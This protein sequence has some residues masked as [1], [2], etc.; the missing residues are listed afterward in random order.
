MTEGVDYCGPVTTSHKGFFL[1]TLEKLVKYWTQGYYIVMKSTPRVPG[2]RPLTDI[3]YKYNSRK[4]LGF[5]TTEGSGST[6]PGDP[7]LSRYSEN[8]SNFSVNPIV[9]PHLLYR[10]LNA[11]NAIEN[12]NR[13]WQFDLEV[14]KYWVTQSGYFILTTTVE[15]GMGTTYGKLLFCHGISEGIDDKRI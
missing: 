11:C 2:D 12:H 7:Y 5:V 14:E 6:E 10:Y 4:V 3:R 15:L 1:D 8:Y 9:H 13:M